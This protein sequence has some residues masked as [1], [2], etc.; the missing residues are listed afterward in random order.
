MI[1]EVLNPETRKFERMK[2]TFARLPGGGSPDNPR[3]EDI[4]GNT[5]DRDKWVK[6]H[7]RVVF[8]APHERTRFPT[9][10]GWGS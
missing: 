10:V 3:L 9:W 7:A 2:L 1:V 4:M 6:Y 5:F 8:A